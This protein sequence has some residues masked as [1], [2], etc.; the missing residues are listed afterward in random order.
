[1]KNFYKT[2]HKE[3]IKIINK[4]D[5][6][7]LMKIEDLILKTHELGGKVIICGNGGSAATSSHFAVDLSLNAKIKSINFNEADLIT[8]FANDFGYENWVKKS[9]E[10]YSNSSDLLILLSCSGNSKNLVNANLF[11]K[12][13]G[14]KVITLTG[15]S[16][17]NKLNKEKNILNIWVNS[18]KYNVI[19]IIHHHILLNVIDGLISKKYDLPKD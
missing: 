9:L 2:R 11:A 5:I 3:I 10:I 4:I 7:K 13:K 15:C 12:K 16:K 1:M 17:N 19:E 14:L 6:K 8:C 18:K